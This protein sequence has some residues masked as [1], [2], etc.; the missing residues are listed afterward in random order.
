M[1]SLFV[2]IY[3]IFCRSYKHFNGIKKEDDASF[4]HAFVNRL[5]FVLCT[6]ATIGYGDVSPATLR[7]RIIT[8]CIILIIFIVILKAFDG[9]INSYNKSIRTYIPNS[10]NIK[11]IYDKNLQ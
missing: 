3:M 6:V 8:I 1:L 9:V 10:T 7:A 11:K 4:W 2:S 5:Y